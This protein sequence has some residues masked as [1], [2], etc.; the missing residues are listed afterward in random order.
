MRKM[1]VRAGDDPDYIT[2]VGVYALISGVVGARIF[3]VIHHFSEFRG[4]PAAVFAVWRGGLEFVGGVIVAVV[5]T[6]IYLLRNKLSV[7][8][9]MDI[10]AVGLMLGLAFGRIGCFFSGCCFGKP[11]EVP[12]AIRFPYGSNVYHSQVF[13]N[14]QRGRLEPHLE[15]P[16]EYF[17][18]YLS[19]NDKRL[20][21]FGLLT[22][23]ERE[24]VTKG[25]YRCLPVHPSQFYS[26]ANALFLCAFLYLPQ[27]AHLYT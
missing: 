9:C 16:G 5:V 20:K 24:A 12:W 2:N 4:S 22:P 11:A 19:E 27:Y 3:F 23:D 25:V 13:E 7:R 21:P 14:Y 18:Y 1:S 8:K 10:L 17:Y 15:L 26:S 6:V